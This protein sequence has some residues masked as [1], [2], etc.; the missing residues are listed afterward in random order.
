M[1]P[2]GSE[3]HHAAVPDI[4]N[5][6][7]RLWFAER[8][9]PAGEPVV[10]LHGLFFSRRLFDRLARRLPQYR[11]LLLDLRGHGRSD[12]PVAPAC[13]TWR[14]LASDV[15]AL[16][17]H[18]ALD[19]AVV[20]GLSLGADVTLAMAAEFPER[21]RAAIVEMP[22][23]DAGRPW[24]ERLFRPLAGALD[25]AGWAVR[26]LGAA[27]RPLRRARLP[28]VAA[29]ADLLS[30]EPGAGAGMLRALL[31]D[32]DTV[33]RGPAALAA[34]RVPTLVIGH[35]RDPLHPVADARAVHDA[36]PGARL[37]I[38]SSIAELRLRPDRYADLVGGFL[39]GLPPVS[40]PRPAG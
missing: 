22:V 11:F 7:V 24:A 34:A 37:A 17:D 39:R 28:E 23:V 3:R 9:D 15:V 35:R 13:Y 8:G 18:L 12:R 25:A 29:A 36:V 21:L 26:P 30:L 2:A 19:R 1:T 33:R 40:G 5:A 27:S 38:V 32:H 6:G 14:H 4:D 20:G 16:L 31:A 10:L